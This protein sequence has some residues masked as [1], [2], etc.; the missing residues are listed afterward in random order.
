M[1]TESEKQPPQSQYTTLAGFGKTKITTNDTQAT[2]PDSTPHSTNSNILKET[3]SS[4]TDSKSW[5]PALFC[6]AVCRPWTAMA[7]ATGLNIARCNRAPPVARHESPFAFSCE[8]RFGRSTHIPIA[9]SVGST[10]TFFV[11]TVEIKL[12]LKLLDLT[13]LE[14][15]QGTLESQNA[16]PVAPLRG[17]RWADPLLQTP[18]SRYQWRRCCRTAR[19]HTR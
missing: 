9:C 12:G 14:T 3:L 11:D 5:R 19:P 1:E 17:G 2:P 13:W 7:T 15:S 4:K 10:V 8:Y 18:R 16:P 6:P